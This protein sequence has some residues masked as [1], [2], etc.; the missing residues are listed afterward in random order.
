MNTYLIPMLFFICSS[1]LMSQNLAEVQGDAV[2]IGDLGIGLT[3]PNNKL[4]V[5]KANP[6]NTNGIVGYFQRNGA[7]DVG[8]SFS[9]NTVNAFG[10]IHPLG[11]GLGFY[12]NRYP[13]NAGVQRMKISNSGFVGIG[14]IQPVRSLHVGGR[15]R[16]DNV[17]NGNGSVLLINA[18][19][20]VF[21]SSTPMLQEGFVNKSIQEKFD[22]KDRLIK[23]LIKR[24]DELE[25]QFEKLVI[26]TKKSN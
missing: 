18:N 3:N 5:Y 20:D 21:K 14:N 12:Q 1:Q 23:S 24:I 19:G 13:G 16:I 11:G 26:S 22:D 17:P 8:I 9:Q 15:V 2:I 10:I 25:H 4:H 7:G 6:S